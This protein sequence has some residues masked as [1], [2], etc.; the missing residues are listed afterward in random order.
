M[1][2][3]WL[4]QT[5]LISWKTAIEETYVFPLDGIDIHFTSKWTEPDIVKENL[6]MN[7]LTMSLINR[8][9]SSQN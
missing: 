6:K 7:R 3:P 5:R 1:L 2:L 4:L 9:F 8:L